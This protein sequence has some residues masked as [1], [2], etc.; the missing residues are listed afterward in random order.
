MGRSQTYGNKPKY[1]ISNSWHDFHFPPSG[2]LFKSDLVNSSEWSLVYR[3]KWS[4]KVVY[5]ILYGHIAVSVGSIVIL[6]NIFVKGK[7]FY[8]QNITNQSLVNA[9]IIFCCSMFISLTIL[10]INAFRKVA[11]RGY[12]SPKYQRFLF[13]R[14]NLL[15]PWNVRKLIVAPGVIESTQLENFNLFRPNCK[16]QDTKAYIFKNNF[17]YPAYY[18][19][20]CGFTSTKNLAGLKYDPDEVFRHNLKDGI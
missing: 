16:I 11:I 2:S 3:I 7:K 20:L 5:L 1:M 13:I 12:Y 19:A 4:I 8:N 17:Y 18:N 15:T 6:Y 14:P 9:G 10:L